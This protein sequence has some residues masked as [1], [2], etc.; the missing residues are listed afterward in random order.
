M[1]VLLGTDPEL[2][3]KDPL[4]NFVSAH[5]LIPGSKQYPHQ[6]SL[7]AIQPDGVA[8]EFNTD[9]AS[10]KEE[11][12][13]NISVVLDQ[14]EAEYKKVRPDLQIVIEPTAT[15][16]RE[17]FDSL[18]LIATELGCQPDFNAYTGKTNKKPETD[19]PSR[20]AGGHIHI[21]W[22]RFSVTDD[23]HFEVC[24]GMIRQFDAVLFLS[25]LLWD[26]DTRRRALYGNIGAFRPKSY[27]V[28]Y[29]PLSNRW[30]SSVGIQEFIFEASQKAAMDFLEGIYYES[31]SLVAE[32]LSSIHHGDDPTEK[33]IRQ[34]L[35]HLNDKF[36]TPLFV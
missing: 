34:Y 17:Y 30:L 26:S 33:E 8:L 35:R 24:R 16:S 36:G 11:F 9:P 4:G 18:P 21:G 28:E 10:T 27:G 13:R 25:S 29:R 12:T 14:L 5:D 23:D 19:E 6:V 20:T 3:L 32:M 1:Q 15:F 22:G 31:D 2:F 7:G